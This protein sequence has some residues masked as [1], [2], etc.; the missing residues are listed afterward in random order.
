MNDS[1]FLDLLSGPPQNASLFRITVPGGAG[2]DPY[3]DAELWDK[4]QHHQDVGSVAADGGVA[5]QFVARIT[6]DDYMRFIAWAPVAGEQQP[7][8]WVRA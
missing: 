2:R 8:K 7:P 1:E 6:A 4:I 5:F 3:V